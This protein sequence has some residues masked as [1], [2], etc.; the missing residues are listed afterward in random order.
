MPSAY[1]SGA[2]EALG[3]HFARLRG[4]IEAGRPL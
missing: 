4:L 2:P 1:L 3:F